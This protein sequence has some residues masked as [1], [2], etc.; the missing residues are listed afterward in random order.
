MSAMP[1]PSQLSPE[2]AAL[3]ARVAA[4]TGPLVDPTTLP[5]AEGRALSEEGNRRWNVDLPAMAAI[6]EAFVADDAD[7]GT[8]RVRLKVLVPPGAGTGAIIFVHGGGFA[9]CSPETHERCARVL[10]LESGLPVLLP[11]YRLAP[12]HPYPAG[13]MDVIA[14]IRRAFVA[15]APFGVVA[16]PLI[17]SGDLRAPISHWP[18]CCTKRRTDASQLPALFSST[19]PM[20]VISAPNPTGISRTDQD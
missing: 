19:A 20:P 7:L 10:A 11:E 5:P 16:G 17:V 6:G 3:L 18:P 1:N 14:T 4:E 2:M 12:E 15:S 13:L 8:G 9:F